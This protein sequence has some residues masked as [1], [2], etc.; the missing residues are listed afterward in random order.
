LNQSGHADLSLSLKSCV[1]VD[2][3][4]VQR[5]GEEFF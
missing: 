1:I 3:L 5:Q 2:G 4:T